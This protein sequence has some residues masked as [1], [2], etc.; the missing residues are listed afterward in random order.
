MGR[1]AVT[2][3]GGFIGGAVCRAALRA[4]HDVV[5]IGPGMVRPHPRLRHYPVWIAD[6]ADLVPMLGGVETVIHA[7][8]RGTPA[9]ISAPSSPAARNEL[10]T[11]LT[12]LEAAAFA[13]VDRVVLIS[14]GG[15]IYGDVPFAVPITEAQPAAPA[16]AYGHVKAAIE[17]LGLAMDRSGRLQCVV[18][19]LSNPYGPGQLPRRGQGLVGSVFARLSAGAPVEVWGDG[20][21]VRD[22]IYIDDAA[23]GLLAAAT[24]PG[25]SVVHV[26]SGRGLATA[27]VVADTATAFAAPARIVHR[28][29]RDAGVCWSVLS[30]CRLTE[31]TGWLPVVGWREGLA[32]TAAWWVGDQ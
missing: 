24:Q 6:P 10:E 14:S 12:V 28:P 19:R 15:T 23:R 20:R 1:L 9:S 5:A 18:A 4:G 8:G 27:R 32:R 17:R 3:A 29:D 26:S 25:G 11:G 31:C 16:S 7:A 2:G 22:Y 30:S 21:A 13:R